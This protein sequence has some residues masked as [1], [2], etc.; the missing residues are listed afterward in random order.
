MAERLEVRL[1]GALLLG[2]GETRANRSVTL[3]RADDEPFIP[4]SALKGAIREQLGR[5]VARERVEAILGREGHAT[6]H[7][8]SSTGVYLGD[9][10]LRD[11]AVRERFRDRHGYATRTQV[12][13]DRRTRRAADQRLFARQVVAPFADELVFQARLDTSRLDERQRREFS[14]AVSAVFAVGAGRSGG[15][16]RVELRV[17][18]ADDETPADFALPESD[19]LELVLEAEEPLCL[20]AQRWAGNFHESLHLIP[21]STLRGAI[22]SAAL[23]QRGI[24]RDL[25]D[26]PAFRRL[27]LEPATCLRFGDALPVERGSLRS[28]QRAPFSLRTCK[29]GLTHGVVDTLVAGYVVARLAGAGRFAPASD[30]CREPGCDARTKV[31][32]GWL[33]ASQPA[34]RVVTRLGLDPRFAR[35]EDGKLFSLELLERGNVFVARLDN[36]GAE[37]RALLADAAR[38]GLR[39]GRGRGQ[40]YG[41]MRVVGARA[42]A[43]APLGERLARFDRCVRE[44][45]GAVGLAADGH[46]VAATLASDLVTGDATRAP[47]SALLAALDVPGAGSV[48]AHVRVAQCGGYSSRPGTADASDQR[49]K[50]YLPAVA[51]GSTLLLRLPGPPDDTLAAALA[52]RERH[53]IGLRR[54]EGFGWVRF[55]DDVHQPGWRKR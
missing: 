26:E 15:L 4:A 55:S 36:V 47:A 19:A 28:P 35:G 16:G 34:L 54:E 43:G 37:A 13:I 45:L 38:H 23:Q 33:D 48:A 25:S 2:G 7:D 20:G 1:E 51:A 53:G 8:G 14:A 18:P 10:E 52:R 6:R 11:D 40:G 12:S 31:V 41:R 32:D 24:T 39:V 50:A 44:L 17:L 46:F 21:A 5:L 3:R 22:V 49:Q 27:V 29:H 30:A 9:A 42:V